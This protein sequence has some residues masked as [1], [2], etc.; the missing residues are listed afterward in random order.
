MTRRHKK[1]MVVPDMNNTNTS[2]NGERMAP[3]SPHMNKDTRD[4]DG[5]RVVTM[6]LYYSRMAENY[7]YYN[8]QSRFVFLMK[9]KQLVSKNEITYP[10]KC[11]KWQQQERQKNVAR[12]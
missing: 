12:R 2:H 3:S 9:Q 5:K 7:V 11:S 8:K 6:L 10:I 1:K 4:T